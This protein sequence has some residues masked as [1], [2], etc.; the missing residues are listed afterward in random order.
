MKNLSLILNAVLLLA[1]IYL[2]YAHFSGPKSAGEPAQ[3]A[4]S[5]KPLSVVYVREDTLLSQFTDFRQK[6]DALNAKK[7]QADA[8][9][10]SRGRA[11]EKEVMGIQQ[12]IQQGLLAPNQIAGEEQRIGQK[13]QALMQ[14]SDRMA[15]EI[16][17]ETQKLNNELQDKVKAV[18][19]T[20]RKE[21]SYDFILNY[22]PGTGVLMVNDSL[23]ITSMVLEK[24]NQTKDNGGN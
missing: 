10:K 2:F 14:E 1:V 17:E 13:Q 4:I 7:E 19:E 16:M 12:K 8:S 9:L 5:E 22:G 21:K 3:A 23:D 24:L 6:M 15:Q 11:L 18:L 20:V